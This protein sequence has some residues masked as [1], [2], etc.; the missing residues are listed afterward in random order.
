M[1]ILKDASDLK[2]HS[3]LY[4]LSKAFPSLFTLLSIVLFVRLAGKEEYGK[5]SL[6]ISIILFTLTFTSGWISQVILRFDSLYSRTREKLRY[7]K[8]VM[9]SSLASVALGA[10]VL[11]AAVGTVPRVPALTLPIGI[12]IYVFAFAYTLKNTRLQVGLNPRE[13]VWNELIRSLV[14]L[15]VPVLLF[16]LFG[17]MDSIMI[18][19]GVCVAY[20]SALLFR[21]GGAENRRL[22]R[23]PFLRTLDSRAYLVEYA[24]Y[25]LPLSLWLAVAYLLNVSDRYIIAYFTSYEDVGVYSA[26]YDLVYK[27]FSLAFFPILMAAHPLIMNNWSKNKGDSLKILKKSLKYEALVFPFIMAGIVAA[28][29]LLSRLLKMDRRVLLG[30]GIPVAVGAFLWQFSMLLHKPMELHNKTPLMLVFVSLALL[31]NVVGNIVF[32][33]R[34]GFVAAAY[35]TVVGAV[36][37]IV[38]IT[39]NYVKFSTS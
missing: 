35:T 37:Y 36:V 8:A 25:G 33:P 29:P 15:I 10:I 6:L 4:F 32:I 1:E 21:L 14:I 11:C 12:T 34:F 13:I 3:V 27:S 28:S 19:S 31:V 16:L 23:V 30:V 7:T 26:V 22:M 9:L 2:K 39:L 17:R 5:Y 18:L 20:L 24:K 38:L